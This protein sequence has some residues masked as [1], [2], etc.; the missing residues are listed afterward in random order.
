MIRI[1]VLPDDV[2][3]DIFD[4]Y[5]AMDP[6]I[7]N[8]VRIEEWQLLI[9]VCRRWRS[10]VFGSPSRLNLRLYC[11][12]ETPAKYTLDAWPALPLII[13]G[14]LAL[15]PVMDNIIPALGQSNRVREV[16]FSGLLD[17]TFEN[18]LAAMQVP[19][20][21]LTDL[22][23]YSIGI[24]PP[25][26]TDSFLGGSAP[27]LRIIDLSGIPC[28]GLPKLLL[29]A[30]HLVHLNLSN[31]PHSGY[32]SPEV[33]VTCLSVLS[34]LESLILE[35]KSPE[36]RPDREGRS[37]PLSKRFILPALDNL[38][39]K[40]VTE[41]LEEFVTRIDTP[42][43]NQMR[44]TFFDQINFDIPRLA[45]FINCTQTLRALDEA[46]IRLNPWTASIRFRYRKSK[47]SFG[48]LRID[49]PCEEPDWQISS[50]EQ[51]CNSSLHSFTTV[52]DL[53]IDHRYSRL[54]WEDYAIENNIWLQL[55][56]PFTAVKNLY[57]SKEFASSIAVALYEGRATEVLA[58]LQNIFV[59]MLE[60]SGPFQESIGGFVAAR[61]HRVSNH[62]IAISVW[63][64][65]SDQPDPEW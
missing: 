44:I 31:V 37:L 52:E 22:V 2:L 57:L 18:V 63:D 21:E 24:N 26:I 62:P 51:V 28:P 8:K 60:P 19:F 32:I 30:T 29:S 23:L 53:Y 33:M 10:L 4:Y 65:S 40:G 17:W 59:E 5:M 25:P 15:T 42:K 1:D 13:A 39:F 36:S 50:I 34:R 56:L 46:H 64:K 54:V 27:R 11:T 47:T 6:S 12:P 7:R 43:L 58:N 38:H 55:L 49:I 45:Q 9:H 14:S 61:Q 20:P 48:Y 16:L 35:F 41:Y 3:L